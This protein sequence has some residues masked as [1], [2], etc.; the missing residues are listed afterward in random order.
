MRPD[1]RAFFEHADANFDAFFGGALLQAN[2]R[3]QAGR[4]AADDHDVI[5]HRLARAILLDQTCGGH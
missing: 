5:F 3:G 2:G 4:A 1:F